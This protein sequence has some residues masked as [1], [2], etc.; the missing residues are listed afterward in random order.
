MRYCPLTCDCGVLPALP[1]QAMLGEMGTFKADYQSAMMLIK[2]RNASAQ[3]AT[4]RLV[5]RGTCHARFVSSSF[6]ACQ[7]NSS[8]RC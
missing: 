8:S 5:L 2:V 6:A 7:W 1:L 4:T 3:P